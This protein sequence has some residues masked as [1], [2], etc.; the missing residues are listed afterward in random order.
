MTAREPRA[1]GAVAF[2]A[3]AL[4]FSACK[5]SECTPTGDGCASACDARGH[6]VLLTGATSPAK[7]PAIPVAFTLMTAWAPD[8]PM[9]EALD[10]WAA[11][12]TQE[13]R[14]VFAQCEV[15][16][17]VQRVQ[18]AAAPTLVVQATPPGSAGGLAPPGVDPARFNYEAGE[19]LTP[20]VKK[21]FEFSR[22]GLQE[23]VISI[24]VV[25]RIDMY[26]AGERSVAG[27]LSFPPLAY[28]HTGDFPARNGVLVGAAYTRCGGL[29][30][31]PSPRVVAHELG[32]M[33][34]NG[35][36]HDDDPKNLM[37]K[38]SG[39]ELRAAQC[40]LL[41][42]NLARLYGA[43]PLVDPGM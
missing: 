6:E 28:H 5:R 30:S 33:V 13:T 37:S 23:N 8:T 9:P 16:V 4:V 12:V 3:A 27:A 40:E 17:D 29:P 38:V 43:R 10:A 7:A 15:G 21:L 11:H 41:R 19:R 34:L 18:L 2:V 35:A 31:L 25:D 14:A 22:A 36:Q 42:A 24:V 1:A 32:H 26:V 39:P 20:Q